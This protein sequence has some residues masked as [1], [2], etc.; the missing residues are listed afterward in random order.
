VAFVT[1]L[2]L[3]VLLFLRTPVLKLQGRDLSSIA[4]QQKLR[5]NLRISQATDTTTQRAYLWLEVVPE[6]SSQPHTEPCPAPGSCCSS[7]LWPRT[8][9]NAQTIKNSFQSAQSDP[10]GSRSESV[11]HVD[12][13]SLRALPGSL[14]PA[15][16]SHDQQSRECLH[17]DTGILRGPVCSD[18]PSLGK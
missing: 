16:L 11:T 7:C 9:S 14:L 3:L 17:W 4:K 6:A 15:A 12:L 1:T 8:A 13:G 18:C 5:H 2:I 10:L